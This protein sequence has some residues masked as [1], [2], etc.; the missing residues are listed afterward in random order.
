MCQRE[1]F[2]EFVTL[3]VGQHLCAEQFTLNLV[4]RSGSPL[5]GALLL[6]ASLWL[7]GLRLF[8]CLRLF[9]CLGLGVGGCLSGFRSVLQGSADAG[10]LLKS[11]VAQLG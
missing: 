2:F 8:A 10:S 1:L 4:F 6:F 9:T 3:D 11:F 7:A 5:L